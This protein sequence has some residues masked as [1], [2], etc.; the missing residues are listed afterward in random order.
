MGGG[1]GGGAS[2]HLATWT[3][4]LKYERGGAGLQCGC[5]PTLQ[6]VLLPLRECVSPHT[7]ARTH[8]PSPAA[9]LTHPSPSRRPMALLAH[10]ASPQIGWRP[11]AAAAQEC[12]I[13]L[14][15]EEPDD[16]VVPCKCT[17]SLQYVHMACLKAWALE[18]KQ[19]TCELCKQVGRPGGALQLDWFAA[20]L[21]LLCRGICS[22]MR[23]TVGAARGGRLATGVGGW[24]FWQSVGSGGG[25]GGGRPTE[26]GRQLRGGA[27]R[28]SGPTGRR[29]SPQST[30]CVCHAC[31]EVQALSSF[32]RDPPRL[33]CAPAAVQGR[34][35]HAL[36][37]RGDDRAAALEV[38]RP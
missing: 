12:R 9:T 5:D 31:L 29:R 1:R 17:G 3:W 36:Q 7:H 23:C 6:C 28:G 25:D 15:A 20:G 30:P 18:K 24:R 11:E 35:R 32:P 33:L 19:L 8:T 4:G 21:V 16:M 26:D 13:C 14:S 22:R 34:D 38:R 2:G 27:L 37:G 10:A